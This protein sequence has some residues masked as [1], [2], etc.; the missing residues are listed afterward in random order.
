MKLNLHNLF[1]KIALAAVVCFSGCM[2]GPKYERP[3]T[4]AQTGDGFFY[5][6]KHK[7]DINELENIYRWWERFGDETTTQL[8]SRALENNYNLKASAARV[9]QAQAVLAEARGAHWPSIA[10]NFGRDRRKSSFNFGGGRANALTTTY[11]QDITVSYV[12]DFFG[13]LKRAERASWADLLATKS[14]EQ[15]LINSII[16][17]VINTRI[18][19]ATLH[20]RLDIAKAN[21]ASRQNTLDI[22]DRRYK[23]GLVGPVDVRLARENLAASK[24]TETALELL[25]IITGHELDVFLGRRPG[26][27]KPLPQT[28]DELPD[29]KPVPIGL[30]ASLLDRRPDVIESEMALRA[31]NERIGVS[32]AQLYPD[33]TLTAAIGGSSDTFRDVF[34]HESEVYS[35]IFNASQPIFKGGQLRAKVK[36]AKAKHAELAANYANTV[37]TA[38]KE[39]EDA[40]VTED[41]LQIQLAQVRTRF[42]EAKGAEDLS[43]QRYQRGVEGILTVLESE[44]RRRIAE[45]E[46]AILKGKIWTTRVNL[47]LALGGDWINEPEKEKIIKGNL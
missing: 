39:V 3:D 40:L 24:S 29:L 1:W 15:T 42:T 30:P 45:V 14:N 25:L 2:V 11:T 5:S 13:K 34:R 6:G 41:M 46:L 16:A 36:A 38:L 37:L 32:I 23:Q 31:A 43:R 8:V 47:F 44:R 19:I 35:L 33:L 21:T 27:S 28:L 22:V 4:A 26:S 18:D 17:S 12:L 10:Y 9:L 20:R 7:Q